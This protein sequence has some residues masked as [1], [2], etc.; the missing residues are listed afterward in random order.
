VRAEYIRSL[1]N[2]ELVVINRA[3]IYNNDVIYRDYLPAQNRSNSDEVP[4]ARENREAFKRLLQD[5][6]VVPFLLYERSPVEQPMFATIN[7]EE[8]KKVCQE[9]LHL[10]E[11]ESCRCFSG[12]L[13]Y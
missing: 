3:F 1:I 7:F 8:R 11:S 12:R 2:G 10:D 6:V 5:K 4:A 13:R 9:A